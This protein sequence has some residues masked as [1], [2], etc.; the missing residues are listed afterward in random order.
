[1]EPDTL[2]SGLVIG[3]ILLVL[4]LVIMVVS[5]FLIPALNSVGSC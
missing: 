5:V 4:G 2:V 3:L 1:M